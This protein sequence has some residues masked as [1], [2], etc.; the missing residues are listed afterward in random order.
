MA[1]EAIINCPNGLKGEKD[2][3]MEEKISKEEKRE[4][5]RR[6]FYQY[7]DR[8]VLKVVGKRSFV[9]RFLQ[10]IQK[11]YPANCM[12]LSPIIA[13]KNAPGCHCFLNIFLPPLTPKEP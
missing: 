10:D 12:N 6:N 5:Y 11:L 7:S 1:L 8:L 13:N 2:W 3:I 4:F 9:L